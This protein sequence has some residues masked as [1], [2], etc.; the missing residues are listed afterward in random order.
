MKDNEKNLNNALS[1][2]EMEAVAG[3]AAE[4]WTPEQVSVL[5]Q[6]S[7]QFGVDPNVFMNGKRGTPA[8]FVSGLVS[9]MISESTSQ[10]EVDA[11]CALDDQLR[12]ALSLKQEDYFK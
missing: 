9:K 11:A 2:D 5:K 3:G 4:D 8:N 12:K 7:S 10:A 6:L 1:D